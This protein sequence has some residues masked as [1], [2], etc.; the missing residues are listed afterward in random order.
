MSR[1][2]APPGWARPRWL[3]RHQPAARGGGVGVHLGSG[4][5]LGLYA[6]WQ[7][8]GSLGPAERRPRPEPGRGDLA[9]RAVAA[10]AE[11]AEASSEA[12][13]PNSF[14]S[15]SFNVFYLGVTYRA[16]VVFLAWLF[17]R[18][19]DA[20]S[21]WRNTGA[22]LTGACLAI[23]FVAVGAT[24]A[25]PAA[26]LR[27]HGRRLRPVGLRRG[28]RRSGHPGGGHAVD[29]R[30]VGLPGGG[31]AIAVSRS[32]WRWLVARPP[33]PH[34]AGRRGTANHWWLDGL[35][36]RALLGAAYWL[37]AGVRRGIAAWR[38]RSPRAPLRDSLRASHATGRISH[39]CVTRSEPVTRGGAPVS[40][41]V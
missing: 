41:P 11:R 38:R 1:R 13:L 17:V 31:G 18:H 30:G 10:P 7:W 24:A 33:G 36:A 3:P 40:G 23:Q 5:V 16:L 27:R 25:P 34:D 20:Y 29:A 8:A 22:L 12:V 39:R 4:I 28:R 26:R 9:L 32:R 6:V 35:V 19:R 2:H 15:Q 37:Q 14:L 21:T